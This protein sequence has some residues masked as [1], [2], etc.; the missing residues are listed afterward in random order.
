[1]LVRFRL[2]TP[3]CVTTKGPT[4]DRTYERLKGIYEI[5]HETKRKGYEMNLGI[6]QRIDKVR[7]KSWKMRFDGFNTAYQNTLLV[8]KWVRIERS[9]TNPQP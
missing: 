5:L 8:S 2:C 7:D 6:T 9:K 1:V 4:G 3:T